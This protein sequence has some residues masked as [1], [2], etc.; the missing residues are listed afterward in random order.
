MGLR[1]CFS[2][3]SHPC[4]PKERAPFLILVVSHVHERMR[5]L[6]SSLSREDISACYHRQAPLHRES[7]SNPLDFIWTGILAVFHA[8]GIRRDMRM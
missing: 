3:L 7:G 4:L 1:V 8:L 5:H 2:G 6:R